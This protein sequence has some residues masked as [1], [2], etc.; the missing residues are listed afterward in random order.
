LVTSR[1]KSRRILRA[2]WWKVIETLETIATL[3]T[4]AIRNLNRYREVGEKNDKLK[5]YTEKLSSLNKMKSN[6][7]ATISHDSARRLRP[8][9]RTARR[10]SRTP[11][12][13]IA[14]S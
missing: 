8:S 9:R 13:S 11:T 5:Q 14:A 6:F 3:A 10:C 7:V 2:R 4:I 1:W 12:R